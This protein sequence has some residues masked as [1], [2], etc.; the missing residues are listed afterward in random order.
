MYI[1]LVKAILD[2]VEHIINREELNL[3]ID[4]E[5]DEINSLIEIM[6]EKNI[7]PKCKRLQENTIA[8]D[9]TAAN[10]DEDTMNAA[11][12]ALENAISEAKALSEWNENNRTSAR[13]RHKDKC[14]DL[15]KKWTDLPALKMIRDPE[16]S[17]EASFA[18]TCTSTHC[19]H[20]V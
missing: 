12:A 2:W 5:V 18:S 19:I 10:E 16:T 7:Q 13:N 4:Q 17:S 20:H 1:D 14:Q 3:N 15:W 6:K 9:F 8:T 11:K